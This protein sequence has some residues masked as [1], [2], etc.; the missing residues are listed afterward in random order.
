M[1]IKKIDVLVLGTGCPKC[2]KLATNAQ[3]AVETGTT[4]S[5]S[6]KYVT[7]PVLM[8]QLGIMSSP[9]LLIR[10]KVVS[11][12]TLLSSTEINKLMHDNGII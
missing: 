2:K 12:G 1:D 6:F 4:A 3:Q 9:A 8:G 11:Q 5:C 10:G 7:D